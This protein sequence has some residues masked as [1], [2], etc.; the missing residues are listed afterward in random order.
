MLSKSLADCIRKYL[1][2]LISS[3]E[4]AYVEG[5]F[6]SKGRILFF[7]YLRSNNKQIIQF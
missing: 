1:H 2:V 6:I 3:K 5:G 7:R 4:T